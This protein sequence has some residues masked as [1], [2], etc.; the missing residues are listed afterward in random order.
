[1]GY[2]RQGVFERPGHGA[3]VRRLADFKTQ[4][5]EVQVDGPVD[6]VPGALKASGQA[7]QTLVHRDGP[8][9]IAQGGA[10]Q[11]KAVQDQ[12]GRAPGGSAR[13][14]EGGVQLERLSGGFPF[15]VERD[16]AA[17]T[18]GVRGNVPKGA[19]VLDPLGRLDFGQIP[20]RNLKG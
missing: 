10:G 8:T 16:R 11:R 1:M 12:G 18:F 4:A 9:D 3:R 14:V 7:A 13:Q 20:V 6:V 17:Q 15:Q 2:S 5:R 19:T